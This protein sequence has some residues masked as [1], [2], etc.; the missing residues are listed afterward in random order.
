MSYSEIPP[1]FKK[2]IFKKSSLLCVAI[3]GAETCSCLEDRLQ[4]IKSISFPL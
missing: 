1:E 2:Y 4:V 3:S